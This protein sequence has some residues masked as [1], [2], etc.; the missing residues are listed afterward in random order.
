MAEPLVFQIGNETQWDGVTEVPLT[1]EDFDKNQ[2]HY[3]ATTPNGGAIKGDFFGLMSPTTSKLVSIAANTLD[4]RV[5]ASVTPEFFPER[6]RGRV[7]LTPVYQSMLMS[8]T[9]VLRIIS[10]DGD[11]GTREITII[12]NELSEAQAI[13]IAAQLMPETRMLRHR[14]TRGDELGFALAKD[15][16]LL[17]SEFS[18]SASLDYLTATTTGQGYV[19]IQE[20]THPTSGGAYVWV[21][22]TGLDAGTGEVYL[23]D[24]R[25]DDH[26]SVQAG[27]QS[28]LW[29]EPIWLARADRLAFRSDAPPAGRQAAIEFEVLP[30]ANRQV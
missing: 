27:L 11:T 3:K 9:D 16:P 2:R 15:N 12:V 17:T 25:S 13:R 8:S 22:F 5:R 19:S 1:R 20:L 7:D 23:V 30:R 10:R 6:E 14:I 21:R 24:P 4:P 18:Y 26:K 28:P 29:S